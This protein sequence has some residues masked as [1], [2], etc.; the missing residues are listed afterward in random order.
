MMLI[1]YHMPDRARSCEI[2]QMRYFVAVAEE[3]NFR[4]AASRLNLAQ[5]ALSRAIRQLEDSLGARLLERTNRR[6][7]LTEV[8]SVF[9]EG[10]HRTLVSAEKAMDD[11]LR[12]RDGVKGHLTIGYTD[13]AIS[14]ALPEIM[15]AFRSCFPD[16]TVELS[17]MVT[18]AQL[19]ALRHGDIEIGFLTGPLA[20]PGLEHITVQNERLVAVLSETHPLARLRSIPLARLAGEPFVIGQA[21][22]WQHYLS[23][24]TA[25]CQS[26]G[27]QPRVVQEA[28][29]SEGIFGLIATDMGLTLHV[30]SARNYFRRGLAIRPLRDSDYRVPTVTAWNPAQ[31]SPGLRRFIDFVVDWARANRL[32][33]G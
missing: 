30:E 18:A 31:V 1:G 27:F 8:G 26:A 14:G 33:Y 29:N 16:I 13:F 23:H 22:Y 9:L 10:C 20:E 21:A 25:V 15:Q 6:V 7:E 24:V 5:P 2:R 17:H 3:L 4:R 19:E 28:Y 12:V 32:S 11:T